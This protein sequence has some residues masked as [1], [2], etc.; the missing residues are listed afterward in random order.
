MSWDW[1]RFFDNHRIDYDTSGPNVSRNHVAIH[2]PFCGPQDPSRHLSVNLE[3]KGWRCWRHPEHRGK[4]PVK[5]VQA[6]LGITNDRA[7]AMVGDAVFVPED[8]M[9]RVQQQFMPAVNKPLPPITLPKEFRAF[10]TGLPSERPYRRY[11]LERAFTD[12]HLA[13]LTR[14]YGV[15]Y[16]VDGPFKGR[17]VFVIRF[18]GEIVSWT[19]RTISSSQTLR[20]KALSTDP[21]RAAREGVP[22]ARGAISHYLL[23]YDRLLEWDA[24]TLVLCEGPIDALKVNLLGAEHGICATCFFTSSPT[25]QQVELLHTLCPQFRRRILL[26]DANTLAMGIRVTAR[27]S[28]LDVDLGTLPPHLKDPGEFNRGTFRKFALA[29]R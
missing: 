20:Y 29:L 8:F 19:G 28:G 17:V 11:L 22:V 2:C 16:C 13:V 23:W 4:S 6:L 27:L 10:G 12:D 21:D 9:Q 7:R 1:T 25:E 24:D 3:G 5:L 14:Q 18:G 26:L 15:R